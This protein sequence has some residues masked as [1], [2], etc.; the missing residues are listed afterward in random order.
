V[1]RVFQPP[2]LAGG[3]G[4]IKAVVVT[5]SPAQLMKVHPAGKRAQSN[6]FERRSGA[7]VSMTRK[8]FCLSFVGISLDGAT[9]QFQVL[10]AFGKKATRTKKI[11]H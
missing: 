9:Q 1:A 11:L 2:T 8:L 7:W 3:N 5:T 4:S 10:M 6:L